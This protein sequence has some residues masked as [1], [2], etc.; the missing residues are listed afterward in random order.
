MLQIRSL[1]R[2]VPPEHWI[3][4]WAVPFSII[5]FLGISHLPYH[6]LREAY[7]HLIL[8]EWLHNFLN[9]VSAPDTTLFMFWFGFSCLFLLSSMLGLV[10]CHFPSTWYSVQHRKS[11][12]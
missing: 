9:T 11:T 12:Q 7:C 8:S 1:P 2:P 4:A 3:T 5:P 10:R 6:F